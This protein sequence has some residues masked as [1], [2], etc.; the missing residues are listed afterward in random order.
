[1]I[2][3]VSNILRDC[4]K[5]CTPQN[6]QKKKL[7]KLQVWNN[8]ISNAYKEMKKANSEWCNAGKPNGNHPLVER[9]KECKQQF[10]RVYRTEIAI[11]ELCLK[12]KVMNIRTK[13]SKIFHLLIN[14]Q[15]QSIRGCI[16]DLHVDNEAMSGEQDILNCFRK[17][18]SNLAVPTFDPDFNYKSSAITDYEIDIITE[19]ATREDIPEPT[20]EEINTALSVMKKGKAEDVFELTV[21]N[22]LYGGDELLYIMHKIIVAISREGH[23]PDLL[24]T[25]LLTPVFKNKGS[26]LDVANYRGITVTPVVG[27]IIESIMKNR[28]RPKWDQQQCPLQRGFTKTSAPLNAAF[29]LEEARREALD[30]GKLLTIVLLDDK[31]AFDVV[32]HT[33]LLKTLYHLGIQD[34]H[35]T[36]IKSLH[37]NASSA[38]KFN[39][40]VSENFN[41]LQ[42]DRQG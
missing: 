30:L 33:N 40:L 24:K 29:I 1:M 16:Q 3:E 12:E 26:N 11:R 22:I 38:I 23:I 2:I 4:A 42:G 13:D 8:D 39:G 31:S 15:R 19:L 28:L 6:K 35:W 32:I 36:L 5:K 27:N 7:G 37:T 9:R 21:E 25:G 14:R 20:Y 18:F 17:H 34:K 10:R 41:I